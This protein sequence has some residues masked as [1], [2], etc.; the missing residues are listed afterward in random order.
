VVRLQPGDRRLPVGRI[1]LTLNVT[2][3]PISLTNIE[4]FLLTDQYRVRGLSLRNRESG[5]GTPLLAVQQLDPELGMRR[6]APATA[7][8][9]LPMTLAEVSSDTNDAVLELYS[10]YVTN[11]VNIGE[12]SVPL[13]TDLTTHLAY[14][15]NQEMV[16]ELGMKY[17][18]A[19]TRPMRRQLIP[20]TT[21]RSDR[22]PLVFVHGT[23]SSPVTWAEMNNTLA[24]DP[25]I[26]K[27]Y[28]IWQ[29]IYGSGKSLVFSAGEL[30]DALT[31]KINE[32]D[33]QGT[34]ALLR[35]MVVIG[36]SQG[37]LLTKLIATETGDKLWHAYSDI[38]L[39]EFPIAPDQR[40]VLRRLL[41]L[42]PLPFVRRVIFIS[43]PHHGSYLANGF[44]RRLAAKLMS[45]PGAAIKLTQD[46]GSLVRGESAE[47]ILNGRL[48]TSLDGMSP[49]NPGL[50]AL[51]N[52]PVRPP[53]KAHSIIA[54]RGDGDYHQ[55]RDGLVTYESAHQDYVESECIV[56][57]FHTCLDKPATIEEVRR[58]LHEHL[59]EFDSESCRQG[60]L[61]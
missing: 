57:S 55:G 34:N 28:Q 14:M 48:P 25:L 22:I 16:W 33:P 29:F 13:E 30:R 3:Y 8:L 38:P 12:V 26:R 21:F 41:F 27:R 40:T 53:I 51:A 7:F 20:A 39:E 46:P 18:F 32:L 9:R 4:R 50:L 36:H 54:V 23:F 17:F 6:C 43:T 15:L 61:R 60:S 59:R 45:L 58:I 5:L 35:Q 24:A 11:A 10:A 42:E 19:P 1:R 47:R 2:N 56:R 52:I 44:A 49:K 31:A 37:G